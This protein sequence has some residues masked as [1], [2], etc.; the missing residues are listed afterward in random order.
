[1]ATERSEI[2]TVDAPLPDHVDVLIVGAGLSGIGAAC[3]LSTE[4]PDKSYLILESRGAT[5]G[6]WDLFRYPGIRSDSDMFTLGYKFRP[7][8]GSKVLADGPSILSYM[9][10]T[11]EKYGV[12]DKIRLH[13][14]VL[15]GDWSSADQRW[16]VTIEDT[17]S[18]ETE[19]ITASYVHACAG[20]YNYDEGFLPEFPGRDSFKGEVIHPQHWPE[21][22]D[23]TG[24]RVVVIGS[25]ATAVTLVPAMA[26]K[27]AHVTMLQRSPTYIMAIPGNDP[28]HK[29]LLKAKVP[30]NVMFGVM[31]RKN[32]G[33][34]SGMYKF[35]R[36]QPKLMRKIIR[37]AAKRQLPENYPV[38]V[39][40][41]PKYDPWDQRLC[42]VPDGDLYKT[43]RRGQADVVTG[44]IKTFNETGI[45]L[46]S[47]EQ[48]DAD[49][50]ITATGLNLQ[51]MGGAEFTIDGQAR[52]PKDLT[53][54]KGMM[55]G[56]VPNFSFVVGY[57]NASWTLKAD[58]VSGYMCR[59]LNYMD[60]NGYS[61]VIPRD[62]SPDMERGPM[63]DLMTG[64]VTR[65]IDE[66]P[67]QGAE[68][69]WRLKQDYK[70]D[71]KQMLDGP[72]DDQVD[73]QR[74]AKQ[75]AKA[76]APAAVA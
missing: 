58:L 37:G 1:M 67:K 74:P 35:S 71:R 21:D 25:G 46:D 66:L 59:L 51:M 20:Y 30:E 27:A 19:S 39:H 60:R 52:E 63:V 10:D 7:W 13:K 34:S 5:G 23:Y 54:Y 56:G 57:T 9:R 47:G 49:I 68:A 72:V 15:R 75:D 29:A 8:P 70:V 32:L 76:E 2:A 55:F 44:T 4:C 45:E 40:F 36:A 69:P 17:E 61:V 64:Y 3:Q 41:N 53:A 48:I 31:R 33:L 42:V 22:L 50:I 6:T 12:S 28:I 14:K 26:D 11:A 38:D 18:G 24:K 73:F 43:I 16:T 62:P 65:S